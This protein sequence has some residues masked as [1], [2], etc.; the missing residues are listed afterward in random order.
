MA[1]I[2]VSLLSLLAASSF[3][4]VHMDFDPN[5]AIG[6][7]LG[8][9]YI[10]TPAKR[11]EKGFANVALQAGVKWF[12]ITV[13]TPP[14]RVMWG[15][16][17][18]SFNPVIIGSRSPA[19]TSGVDPPCFSPQKSTTFRNQT[20]D[21]NEYFIGGS[22]EATNST[23]VIYVDGVKVNN[24]WFCTAQTVEP[25]DGATS[26]LLGLGLNDN[27]YPPLIQGLKDQKHINRASVA[28]FLNNGA[29]GEV[30]FGGVDPTK[31][32]GGLVSTI[33]VPNA[34]GIYDNMRA[35]FTDFSLVD[36]KGV[37]HSLAPKNYPGRAPALDTGDPGISLPIDLYNALFPA[38]GIVNDTSTNLKTVP[39]NLRSSTAKLSFTFGGPN[40]ITIDTPLSQYIDTQSDVPIILP[41]G[42]STPACKLN[43]DTDRS[44]TGLLGVPLQQF[45]YNVFDY[46]NKRIAIGHA[47]NANAGTGKPTAIPSGTTIPGV[48]KTATKTGI[49]VTTDIEPGTVAQTT[50][51]VSGTTGLV[52]H[53][54]KYN[55]GVSN[56]K[57]TPA[58]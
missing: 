54:P 29:L 19:C 9:R 51:V 43:I 34:Q 28:I 23:D 48:T 11:A 41:D 37:S 36:A 24:Q 33:L 20:G 18:G 16:D 21:C 42:T 17:T 7:R 50:T 53:T 58:A 15:I 57:A 46:D 5:I 25:G 27:R 52:Y 38:L 45:M 56:S 22:I 8:K 39:C 12:N 1:I 6:R 32:T 55:L 4:Q 44:D 47:N 2:Q 14:Q 35:P 30:T 26:G 49:V 13:G 40:G 31:Y 10:P 3:A